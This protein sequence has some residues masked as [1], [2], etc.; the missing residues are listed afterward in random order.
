[1]KLLPCLV[2]I[3]LVLANYWHVLDSPF[4][5]DSEGN[6]T[7]E[8][9]EGA[10]E[11]FRLSSL[12]NQIR[13]IVSYSFALTYH[14]FGLD[15][16]WF[17][18]GNVIM[19]ALNSALCYLFFRLLF[20]AVL[21][22]DE[23][24]KESN[25]GLPFMAA[26]L[27]A[28]NPMA[29]YATAYVIQRF[30]VVAT[31]FSILAAVAWIKGLQ[32]KGAKEGAARWTARFFSGGALWYYTAAFFYFCAVHSK[33]H[34]VMLPLVFAALTVLF[35]KTD[36][37][38]LI[39][40]ILPCVL[41]LITAMHIIWLQKW[42]IAFAY[43]PHAETALANLATQVAS[44]ERGFDIDH[45]LMYPLSVLNQLWLYFRYLYLWICLDVTKMAIHTPMPFATD[46]FSFP[47]SL[48]VILFICYLVFALL[49]LFAGHTRRR[50]LGLG[51][52]FPVVLFVTELST[53]RFHENF[54]LYR[55]YLWMWGFFS[56]LPFFAGLVSRRLFYGGIFV[57]CLVMLIAMQHRLRPFSDHISRWEDAGKVMDKD[58]YTIPALYISWGNLGSAYGN[59]G[60]VEDAIKS[61]KRSL[62]HFPAYQ[63]GWY[64]L[65]V[66][67]Y[68]AQKYKE[69]IPYFLKGVEDTPPYTA[70]SYRLGMIYYLLDDYKQA[71]KYLRISL[72]QNPD[73]FETSENLGNV[74]FKQGRVDEAYH[75]YQLSLK[76]EP[77]FV[78]GWNGLGK[79]MMFRKDYKK[80]IEYYE[81]ATEVL[82]SYNE[83]YYN[84]GAVYAEL[85]QDEK[86]VS[87]YQQALLRD[88]DYK[89]ALYNIGNALIK[90][91]RPKEAVTY[92]KRFLERH[93][94]DVDANHNLG[95]AYAHLG[96]HAAA[97]V[98]YQK[99][100]KWEPGHAK[101]YYN[102]GNSLNAL[103]KVVEALK[104]YQLSIKYQPDYIYALHNAG[105][106]LMGMGK[107]KEARPYFLR[108]LKIDSSFQPSREQLQKAGRDG[109]W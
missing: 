20:G 98:Q 31:F 102:M 24:S 54:T 23:G 75:Y 28:L 30:V 104:S 34:A 11:G 70:S 66:V 74:L 45:S 41:L 80:A 6:L 39:P 46:F 106:M 2:L 1:M 65:G 49:S 44:V 22:G 105:A 103:G 88:P 101:A 25:F 77:G 93:P 8:S 9:L 58:Y 35:K 97:V 40:M 61:Y 21:R 57:Y 81:R 15:P 4:F 7:K 32:H 52:I 43:E 63:K 69:A 109:F 37:T 91:S 92:Y 48:G 16:F 38:S 19:H 85:G 99:V 89:E 13:A 14:I 86:A 96:D 84:L 5:F 36:K 79:V 71:E 73:H 51:L 55:S 12:I 95:I 107:Q 17:R 27:F 94:D 50:L 67:Y 64:G 76:Q 3:V 18:L 26:L 83:S 108:A 87:Y 56:V 29:I 53:V 90:L 72:K 42:V 100:I 59:A 62:E 33:E 10:F 82:S 60:R 47:E 68:N 78:K